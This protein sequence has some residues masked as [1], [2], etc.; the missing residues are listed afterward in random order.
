MSQGIE[1]VSKV[2]KCPL[3]FLLLAGLVVYSVTRP[4]ARG[5]PAL[6][7]RNRPPPG[8]AATPWWAHG[9][10]FFSLSVGMGIMVTPRL[11]RAQVGGGT[12]AKSAR[13]DLARWTPW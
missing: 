2:L 3:L 12:L 1:K 5:G 10:A 11:L 6:P 9:Q 4:G 7:V 13:L 8:S